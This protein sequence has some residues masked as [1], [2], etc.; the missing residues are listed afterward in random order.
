MK[1]LTLSELERSLSGKLIMPEQTKKIKGGT[2]ET[3]TEQNPTVLPEVI[4]PAGP[5]SPS[6]YPSYAWDWYLNPSSGYGMG[7]QYTETT[8][9][10]GGGT[11]TQGLDLAKLQTILGALGTSTGLTQVL[12]DGYV[13]QRVSVNISSLKNADYLQVVGKEGASTMKVFKIGGGV[14]A[15]L[16]MAATIYDGV[17][18][19]NGWGL[20][21]TAD[22]FITGATALGGPV[23]WL[24]GGIYFIADQS[25][26]STH[27][28]QSIT[29]YYLD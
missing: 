26:Q 9:G 25:F 7:Y 10:G 1:K 20:H 11:Q 8:S 6:N 14:I 4:I 15:G 19:T 17:T 24:I 12:I 22:L 16:D 27:E 13:A 28:G 29:E 5:R 3:S 18:N 21:H 2:A 23:G